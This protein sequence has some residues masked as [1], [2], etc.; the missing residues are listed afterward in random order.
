MAV[1][2]DMDDEKDGSNFN[3]ERFHACFMA[4]AQAESRWCSLNLISPPP[5]GEYKDLPILRNLEHLES[6]KLACGFGNFLG[7]LMT[8]I[9]RTATPNLTKMELADPAAVLYL[10]QPAWLRITHSLKT[11][12]IQLSKRMDSPVDILP[13]LQGLETFEARHLY[14]PICTPGASLPLTNTLQFLSLRSVSVQW[15]AGH[16][17]PVLKVCHIMFPHHADTIQALQPVTLPSC[18]WLQYNSNDLHLLTQFRLPSLNELGVASGQWNVWRGNNQLATLYSGVVARAQNLTWL[19]LDVK[20]SEQLLV[21]ML[22]HLQ[23][24]EGLWLVL[25]SPGSL[26]KTF[27]QEFVVRAP[28]AV[29]PSEMAGTPSQIISPLC[30]SLESIQLQ[31]KRWLRGPDKKELLIALGDI[32]A[33]REL[34][35]DSPFSL[36]VILDEAPEGQDWRIG[37]PVTKL[38][39]TWHGGIQI[40]I[41]TPHAIISMSTYLIGN[42]GDIVPLPFKEIE[43]LHL[44]GGPVGGSSFGFL[45]TFDHVNLMG[46]DYDRPPLPTPLPCALPIFYTLRVLVVESGNP[47]FLAGH[48]FHKLERC[49]VGKP[50][51]LGHNTSQRVLTETQM[52]VC[53]R[54][55]IEDPY[56]LATLKLPRIH[57]LAIHFSGADFNTIWEK[58]IAVK[59][60]LSRLNLLH[61]RSCGGADLIP[62]LRSLPSLEILII[63]APIGVDSFRAF[64]PMD[65][66]QASRLKRSSEEGQISAVLCP[67]LQSVRIE[68]TDHYSDDSM[69]IAFLK[70]IVTQR[71][72]CGSPLKSFTF[73][74]P[75]YNPTSK[76]ELIGSDGGSTMEKILLEN[77]AE[78]F[79]LDI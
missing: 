54:V 52:P 2:V 71:T 13:H 11:L 42:G 29:G 5:H 48:T 43:Y 36:N 69:L 26:S 1:T 68:G 39:D 73:Y 79:R 6:F 44:R 16:V 64:L 56:L 47:S 27:F 50:F 9:N 12:K 8:A 57:E 74:D 72:M 17:F 51:R 67:M 18:S 66:I 59:A 3:A 63:S 75:F 62:I 65:V 49:R 28:N 10:A 7:P 38:L 32:V 25:A 14:L 35:T 76:Y 4:A 24:L 33:S 46:C 41:S 45:F 37:K 40:G 78:Y 19:H 55:D 61:M 20:C 30:P 53:T 60:N 77:D 58:H 15:M 31:Y 34:E 21:Y 70:E 22:R 23:A